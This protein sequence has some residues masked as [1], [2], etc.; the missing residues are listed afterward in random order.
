MRERGIF[1]FFVFL[2]LAF[3]SGSTEE[4]PAAR[5]AVNDFAGLLSSSEQQQLEAE[6]RRFFDRTGA[7][8]VI[9]TFESLDGVPIEDY[10][11][12]LFEKWKIGTKGLDKGLLILI[13]KSE[14]KIRFEVGYGLEEVLPDGRCGEIIRTKITPR[15]KEGDF[16]GGISAGVSEVERILEKYFSTGQVERRK[17]DSIDRFPPILLFFIVL[18]IAV[19]VISAIRKGAL[20]PG[21]YRRRSGWGGFWMGSGLGGWSGG[22]GGGF[23]GGFGGFGGGA[24]GGG[25]ATGG[26]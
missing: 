23:S 13:A 2:F 12:G 4:Y 7:A 9:A 17:S 14:R 10:G 21:Y 25:G 8:L 5:G 16:S 22:G 19:F 26:W 20:Y 6:L 18:I 11:V 3:S 1:L 15:F 24:S